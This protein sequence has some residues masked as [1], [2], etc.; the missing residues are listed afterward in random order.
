MAYE[1]K[2]LNEIPTQD[3]PTENTTIMAFDGGV[4]KQIPAGRFDRIDRKGLVVDLRG[5]DLSK[6]NPITISDINYDQIYEAF[7]AGQNV[8]FQ[9]ML[10]GHV[11]FLTPILLTVDFQP[12][13]L[14]VMVSLDRQLEI[15]FTN[16]SYHTPGPVG[17]V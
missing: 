17:P 13:L 3:A 11:V 15:L 10:E 2:N 16:G 1:F 12:G 7:I 14:T 6:N 9:V 5:Y 4:P 8:V